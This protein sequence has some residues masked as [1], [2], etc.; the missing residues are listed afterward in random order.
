MEQLF[1]N[2]TLC[3][4]KLFSCKYKLAF[5]FRGKIIENKIDNIQNKQVELKMIF[6]KNKMFY[7]LCDFQD[8]V[9]F[10]EHIF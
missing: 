1:D 5:T 6:F 7:Q 4:I 8:D 2:F 3:K 10:V 9:S